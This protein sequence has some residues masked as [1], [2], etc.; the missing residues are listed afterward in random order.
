MHR[1][2]N[3]GSVRNR[4]RFCH[5]WICNSSLARSARSNP[6]IRST[7]GWDRDRVHQGTRVLDQV[8]QPL[9]LFFPADS[10]FI[11]DFKLKQTTPVVSFIGTGESSGILAR[12]SAAVKSRVPWP[13]SI[14]SRPGLRKCL[15][16]SDTDIMSLF[17]IWRVRICGDGDILGFLRKKMIKGEEESG[18][19]LC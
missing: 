2:K 8:K 7:D 14:R 1:K 18:D 15:R 17:E 6:E 16:I 9:P 3:P 10:I 12:K 5:A 19:E 4:V 13:S 11:W